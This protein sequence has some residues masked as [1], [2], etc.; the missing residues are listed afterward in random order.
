[1]IEPRTTLT[2]DDAFARARRERAQAFR[3]LFAVF[4]LPTLSRRYQPAH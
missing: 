3:A 2:Y 1:M 4:R